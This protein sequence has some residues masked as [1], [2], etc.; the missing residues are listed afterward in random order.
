MN[1][2]PRPTIRSR[3]GDLTRDAVFGPMLGRH[4]RAYAFFAHEPW[5]LDLWRAWRH[6]AAFRKQLDPAKISRLFF[7]SYSRSGSHNFAGRLHYLPEV[8]V[9][10][11]NAF[12][13]REDPWQSRIQIP[14]IQTAHFLGL[15][16]FGPHGIQDKCG[17][18]IRH[19][20]HFN[21]RYLDWDG[22][23]LEQMPALPSDRVLFYHR[24]IFRVLYSRDK[25]S[26]RVGKDK[27]KWAVTD[28][29]FERDLLRHR[30]CVSAFTRLR[31]RIPDRTGW[32][33][34]EQFCAQPAAVFAEIC[35]WLKIPAEHTGLWSEPRKFFKTAFGNRRPLEERDGSLWCPVRNI[36]VEGTG[37]HYN[38]L[39]P[40]DR[41][42]AVADPLDRFLT[43]PRLAAARR[44]LGS[45]VTDFLM[46]DQNFSYA[47]ATTGHLSRLFAG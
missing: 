25:A 31:D 26:E 3:L 10:R 20:V 21:N 34:H 14:D 24:N 32:C 36:C 23:P 43:P 16:V 17:D 7:M 42:R 46:S 2:A 22:P 29:T 8:F 35:T 39:Q 19:V 15:S 12:S 5:T 27:T 1:D 11:E 4:N 37:G 28:E 41:A 13:N 9:M 40:V 44:I 33:F 45:E 38:P 30:A 6:A 47:T 18:Q